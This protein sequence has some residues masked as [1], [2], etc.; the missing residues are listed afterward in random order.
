MTPRLL[1]SAKR[2]PHQL[3]PSHARF[4]GVEWAFG[5]NCS[6]VTSD[7]RIARKSF[8]LLPPIQHRLNRPHRPL[9]RPRRPSPS[10]RRV[11][12]RPRTLLAP[13]TSAR[14]RRRKPRFQPRRSRRRQHANQPKVSDEPIFTFERK[15]EAADSI[16]S[17]G[18]DSED[19]VFSSQTSSKINVPTLPDAHQKLRPPSGQPDSGS[20]ILDLPPSEVP[21]LE[22]RK[23]VDIV[24]P[25]APSGTLLLPPTEPMPSV[26]A[27]P[28]PAPQ[29]NPF[30]FD[31]SGTH[32]TLAERPATLPESVPIPIPI[33]ESSG[34]VAERR[35]ARGSRERDAAETGGKFKTLALVLA[36]YSLVVTALAVYGLFFKPTEKLDPGHPLSTIPDNFGE[37]DPATRKK[38]S[39]SKVPARWRVAREPPSGSRRQDRSRTIDDRAGRRREDGQLKMHSRRRKAARSLGA[40]P[41]T[42]RSCFTSRSRIPRQRHPSFRSTRLSRAGQVGRQTSDPAADRQTNALRRRDLLALR[43]QS[44]ARVRGTAERKTTNRS[45]RDCPASTSSSRLRIRRWPL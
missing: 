20:P 40:R 9:P 30:A 39:Q 28:T 38:V 4:A 26:P 44:Q 7:V 29:A 13:S 25:P 33:E 3:T 5:V 27:V 11:I 36:A 16:L 32:S 19:E 31:P 10:R 24:P 37:F 18:H 1:P 43:R 2:C 42:T 22:L 21:T 8:S 23:P 12:N 15:Q 45:R 17:E 6:G 14:Y 35:T 41:R 34:E